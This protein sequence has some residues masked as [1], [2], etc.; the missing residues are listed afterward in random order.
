MDRNPREREIRLLKFRLVWAAFVLLAALLF[1]THAAEVS[2]WFIKTFLPPR[3]SRQP[4]EK[5]VIPSPSRP[6]APK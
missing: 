5:I 4:A 2:Q 1:V 3:F 6:P